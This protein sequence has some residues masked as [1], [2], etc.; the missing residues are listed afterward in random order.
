SRQPPGNDLDREL[1]GAIIDK[2][3]ANATVRINGDNCRRCRANQLPS[4]RQDN[5]VSPDSER[6]I[7]DELAIFQ[8]VGGC[9]SISLVNSQPGLAAVWHRS[10]QI[11]FDELRVVFCVWWN[12][13]RRLGLF[14]IHYFEFQ[15]F[16]GAAFN[17]SLFGCGGTRTDGIEEKLRAFA[18]GG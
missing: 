2:A 7:E 3:E 11:N 16:A 10:R 13:A 8:V 17:H 5:S 12:Q 4:L 14:A 9:V 18:T 1:V 15:L 6:T